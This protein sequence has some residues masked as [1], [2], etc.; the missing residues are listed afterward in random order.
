MEAH[1]PAAVVTQGKKHGSGREGA[2]GR[3]D[4]INTGYSED[5]GNKVKEKENKLDF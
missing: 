2:N 3:H 5:A 1:A 4:T